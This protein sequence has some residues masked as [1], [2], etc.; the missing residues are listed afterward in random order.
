MY[1]APSKVNVRNFETFFG[2]LLSTFCRGNCGDFKNSEHFKNQEFQTF[3]TIW[4]FSW[5][6]TKATQSCGQHVAIL[7]RRVRGSSPGGGGSCRLYLIFCSLNEN[8]A[9][10]NKITNMTFKLPKWPKMDFKHKNFKNRGT[11]QKS[12][13]FCASPR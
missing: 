5:I 6:I 3:N 8:I 10:I 4:N 12:A 7:S 9:H 1:R 11:Q 2:S 13:F